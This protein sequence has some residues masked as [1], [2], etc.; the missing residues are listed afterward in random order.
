MELFLG[1]SSLS[2]VAVR[3]VIVMAGML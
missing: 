3:E 2:M 1:V